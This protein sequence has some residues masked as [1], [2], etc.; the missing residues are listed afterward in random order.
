MQLQPEGT[1]RERKDL[2]HLG[3][4]SEGKYSQ[5]SICTYSFRGLQRQQKAKTSFPSPVRSGGA[6]ESFFAVVKN[7]GLK[8]QRLL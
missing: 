1:Q 7:E 8:L 3:L 4:G 6:Y 5:R 2:M